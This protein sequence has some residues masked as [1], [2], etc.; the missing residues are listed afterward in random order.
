MIIY[1]D[2]LMHIK[3]II[4]L[5]NKCKKM[6]HVIRQPVDSVFIVIL[7]YYSVYSIIH[8]A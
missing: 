5:Y 6:L 7:L 1:D 3:Y 8:E 4:K 2:N